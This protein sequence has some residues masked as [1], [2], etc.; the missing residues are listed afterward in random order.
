MHLLM[1]L[2]L[3][4]I[5]EPAIQVWK[6]YT[7]DQKATWCTFFGLREFSP[8]VLDAFPHYRHTYSYRLSG[9]DI[10]R[11]VFC[12]VVEIIRYNKMNQMHAAFVGN[13]GGLDSATTVALYAK[14]VALMK[15]RGEAFEFI[16]YG[17]PIESNPD[18]DARAAET[19]S[20]F[21]VQHLTIEGL[22]QV[23]AAF[24]T[25]LTPLAQMCALSDEERRRAYGNVKARIRMIVNFFGTAQSGRYV[26]STDNLS[27]LYMAFWTLMGDVG[28]FGPIQNIL[29]GLE[30]PAVA[31]A[32][33][34]PD[35]T[36]GAKPTDGLQVHQSLDTEEGGDT[37]AFR[38]VYYPHIDAIICHAAKNGLDLFVATPVAV[39]ATQIQTPSATQA[40]VDS[41]TAQMV[42]P[43]AVWKRTRGSIG[44]SISR[45]ELGLP[46]VATLVAQL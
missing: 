37:D 27:E 41:L 17:L 32:L 31:Y 8:R 22:D 2:P 21:G 14:A 36:L 3:F 10:A 4:D 6:A 1:Q 7:P 30:L 26:V 24:K 20:T 28:G 33:G 23:F 35:K 42:S 5:R 34:V 46:S 11:V 45:E 13:S 15:D 12:A 39:D 9:E 40:V 18:H 29:K 25:P 44:S 16:S 38:G 43:A 19:A